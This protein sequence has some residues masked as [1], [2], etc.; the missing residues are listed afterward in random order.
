MARCATFGL[1][2]SPLHLVMTIEAMVSCDTYFT[3]QDTIIG[4]VQM[5]KKILTILKEYMWTNLM[6]LWLL[7]SD[8]LSL[9][10][11]LYWL[12]SWFLMIPNILYSTYCPHQK[13]SVVARALIDAQDDSW[14]QLSGKSAC[15]WHI[16]V[17]RH[18]IVNEQMK[19]EKPSIYWSWWSY[20]F[21]VCGTCMSILLCGYYFLF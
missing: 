3:R 1:P 19:N 2:I 7:A 11:I 8:A 17:V 13:P 16:V 9:I 6:L 10:V 5:R 14:N 20:M 18:P 12:D 15:A 21:H 4:R